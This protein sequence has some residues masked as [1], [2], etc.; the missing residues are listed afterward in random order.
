[1]LVKYYLRYDN[2]TKTRGGAFGRVRSR[3]R[4]P[5]ASLEFSVDIILPSI[6]LAFNRNE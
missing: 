1:M 5:G 4:F 3:V 6:D 2:R